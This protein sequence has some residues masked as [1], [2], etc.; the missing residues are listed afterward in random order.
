MLSTLIKCLRMIPRDLR[1]YWFL[2]APLSLLTAGLETATAGAIYVLVK[3]ATEPAQLTSLPVV[4][5]LAS[6][7]PAWSYATTVFVF[8]GLFALFYLGKAVFTAWAGYTREL[9]LGKASIRLASMFFRAYMTAP[10]SFHLRRNSSELIHQVNDSIERVLGGAMAAYVTLLLEVLVVCGLAGAM[11]VASPPVTVT[12]GAVVGLFLAMFLRLTRAEMIRSGAETHRLSTMMLES[13]RQGL[14]AI[15]EIKVLGREGHFLH[16]YDGLKHEALRAK[17]R[18]RALAAVPRLGTEAIFAAGGLCA[19]AF[20][21]FTGEGRM[22]AVPLLAI[23]AYGALRLLPA[24]N[25]IPNLI[26]EIRWCAVPVDRLYQDYTALLT[27]PARPEVPAGAAASFADRIAVENVQFAYAGAPGWALRDITL[28]IGRGESVGI[29]GPTGAG[30]TTLMDLII[31]LAEP[32]AG[33]VTVDGRD[34]REIGPAWRRQ[35]GYVP[36]MIYLVDDSIRRNVGLGLPDDQIDEPRVWAAVRMANLEEVI[37]ALPEGLDTSVGEHGLR[38]SGGQRQRIGIARALYHD[39][40][41][42][43]FDEA[44]SSLDSVTEAEVIRAIESLQGEKTLIVIAHRLSTV[45]G[46]QRLVFLRDGRIQATGR[47]DELVR[48]SDE[49]RRMA[50][51]SGL[52]PSVPRGA[53]EVVENVAE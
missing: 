53:G 29:V 25:R 15:K 50:R 24:S 19:L 14:G 9:A 11:L 38:L 43:V 33:R 1:W 51:L 5:T 31:G 52:A 40:A 10:Y 46:C 13:V 27:A 8:A 34:L 26:G 39:P 2:A 47:F 18:R 23:Y 32:V 6:R 12:V 45:R 35:I 37:R 16:T 20:Y 48:A 7:F 28:S 3:I 49:F 22:D 44:T 21:A 30:K 42:L 36:Q 41:V 4:S 17:A